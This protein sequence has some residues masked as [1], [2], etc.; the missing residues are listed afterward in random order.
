MSADFTCDACVI[1]VTVTETIDFSLKLFPGTTRR[2]KRAIEIFTVY[3]EP[4]Q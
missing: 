4:V 3:G 1:T 2:D